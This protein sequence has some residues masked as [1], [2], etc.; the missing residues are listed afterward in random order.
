MG[1]RSRTK[2]RS[3]GRRHHRRSGHKKDEYKR[4]AKKFAPEIQK[5]VENS[6]VHKG[7]STAKYVVPAATALYIGKRILDYLERESTTYDCFRLGFQCLTAL[8]VT[9]WGIAA[10]K[11]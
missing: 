3:H 8:G 10:V 7:L 5:V 2:S 1:S 11:K 9:V 6:L 4:A